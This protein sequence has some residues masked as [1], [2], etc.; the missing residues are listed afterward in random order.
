MRQYSIA[1]DGDGTVPLSVYEDYYLPTVTKDLSENASYRIIT[2]KNLSAADGRWLSLSGG[3]LTGSLTIN[4]ADNSI[5]NRYFRLI[6]KSTSDNLTRDARLIFTSTLGVGIYLRCSTDENATSYSIQNSLILLP[7]STQ[8]RKPLEI[9]SGGT[10]ATS[11]SGA[12]TNLGF[13]VGASFPTSP[14]EDDIHFLYS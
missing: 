9:G 11:K 7:D 6:R 10:G 8:L 12:R 2:T 13:T 4:N 1:A 3:A 14:S 5:S